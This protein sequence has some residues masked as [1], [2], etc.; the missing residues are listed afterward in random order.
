MTIIASCG[1]EVEDISHL[2]DCT[3]AAY[4]REGKRALEY[5]SL[6]KECYDWRE[7]EGSVLHD[8]GEENKWMNGK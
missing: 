5:T 4:T 2:W 1:H 8:E 6:C 3:V 7:R